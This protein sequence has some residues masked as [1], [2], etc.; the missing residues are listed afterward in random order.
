MKSSIGSHIEMCER[1]IDFE[2]ESKRLF[3]VQLPHLGSKSV[4]PDGTFWVRQ[5]PRYRRFVIIYQITDTTIDVLRI[6]RASRNNKLLP[7]D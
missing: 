5:I 7:G 1:L 6:I 3:S 4:T 2:I